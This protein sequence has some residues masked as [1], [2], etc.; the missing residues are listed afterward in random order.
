MI[1]AKRMAGRLCWAVLFLAGVCSEPVCA[2]AFAEDHAPAVQRKVPD[3]IA[4]PARSQ[5]DELLWRKIAY[6]D[7]I[8]ELADDQ[9][10]KLQLAGNGDIKHVL[11]RIAD[12]RTRSQSGQIDAQLDDLVRESDSLH[13]LLATGPFEK[14][15]LFEK[16]QR[17]NLTAE[18]LVQL[19]ADAMI[20]SSAWI[21]DFGEAQGLSRKH[22][23]PL[24]VHFHADWSAPCCQMKAVLYKPKVIRYLHDHCIPVFIEDGRDGAKRLMREHGINTIPADLLLDAEGLVISRWQGSRT[25]QSV[26]EMLQ[27]VT[28]KLPGATGQAPVSAA[29]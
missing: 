8:C 26:L 21:D 5:L 17:R 13:R 16:A 28:G 1:F 3:L 10:K 19:N 7:A 6:L 25:E 9:K 27:P 29:R 24:L 20:F 14:P 11:D 18:Q 22:K 12:V 15:S 2:K 4:A 23:R